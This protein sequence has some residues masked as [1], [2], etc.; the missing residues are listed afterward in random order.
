MAEDRGIHWFRAIKMKL[1]I[2]TVNLNNKDGL[3]KTINSVIAQTFKDYEWIVIDGGSSDG[4]KEL[5]RKYSD[6]FSYWVSEPD[7]GV[8]NAMNKGIFKA[9]GE[10]L[11]F[12]NS[13]DCYYSADTLTNLFACHVSSDILFGYMIRKLDGSI[14]NKCMMKDN[15]LWTDFYNHNIP[16]QS[17]FI[18]K[19]IFSKYGMYDESY[20]VIADWKFFINTI[21]YHSV[22][23]DFVPLCIA[24]FESGGLSSQRHEYEVFR[25]RE[26]MFP[27]MLVSTIPVIQSYNRIHSHR[28]TSF[29]YSVLYR[30][31]F[32]FDHV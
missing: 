8:Y 26:E 25:L 28:V 31:S 30:F 13:G 24:I 1:S 32:L 22:S 23:F 19:S 15:L 3:Q 11:N 20:H 27:P 9:R 7:S 2:I 4:S 5:I 6:Y 12:L 14:I 18:K 17:S 21:V 29:L 16:H 10:Y